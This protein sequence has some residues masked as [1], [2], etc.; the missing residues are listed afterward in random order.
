MS[1]HDWRAF[2]PEVIEEVKEYPS[3]VAS[4]FKTMLR[5][6]KFEISD[7]EAMLEAIGK[8]SQMVA[9]Q[10]AKLQKRDEDAKLLS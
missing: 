8:K 3:K 9:T 5:W 10:Q 6:L 2:S 7:L 4:P 1:R